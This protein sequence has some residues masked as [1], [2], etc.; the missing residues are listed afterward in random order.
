MLFG[1]NYTV[2]S[3]I[4]KINR[5][6]WNLFDLNQYLQNS[7]QAPLRKWA[8]NAHFSDISNNVS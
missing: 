5:K 7:P 6:D 3:T 2:K 8:K 4:G 1:K